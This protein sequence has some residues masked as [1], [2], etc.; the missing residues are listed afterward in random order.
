MNVLNEIHLSMEVKGYIPCVLPCIYIAFLQGVL[1]Y[2][3]FADIKETKFAY[4]LFH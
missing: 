4:N 2:R 3:V 1:R